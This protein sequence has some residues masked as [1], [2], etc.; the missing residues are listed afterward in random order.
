MKRKD[1]SMG[2]NLPPMLQT[3]EAAGVAHRHSLQETLDDLERNLILDALR[4]SRGNIA[5]A[6]RSLGVSERV[7]GLRVRKH[8]IQARQFH[9]A[10]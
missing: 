2:C 4:A 1:D 9:T 10:V 8:G 3:A 6:A 5:R 7:M